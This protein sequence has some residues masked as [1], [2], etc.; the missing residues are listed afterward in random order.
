MWIIWIGLFINFVITGNVFL[1]SL[2]PYNMISDVVAWI[3]AFLFG[4]AFIGAILQYTKK[5]S[6]GIYFM[7]VG[8]FGCLPFGLIV[9]VGALKLRKTYA[10]RR[11][12]RL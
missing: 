4:V 12:Y 11:F 3:M 9:V 1:A 2:A 10:Y 5:K 6:L 7:I 8:G